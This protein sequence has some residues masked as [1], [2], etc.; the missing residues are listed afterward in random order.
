LAIDDF[1][2]GYSCLNYLQRFPIDVLKIDR[3]FVANLGVRDGGDAICGVILSI[4]QRLSL[5]TVAEGIER[6]SQLVALVE[7]G[8]DYGQG[9]Y[10]SPPIS[11]EAVR[12]HLKVN[13][14]MQ[15]SL[16]GDKRI[17]GATEGKA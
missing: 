13:A 17:A 7:H 14:S 1:G 4:A 16:R 9:Y 8:C 15:R 2:T 12:A 10:F 6:E 3:S 5:Q 11:A